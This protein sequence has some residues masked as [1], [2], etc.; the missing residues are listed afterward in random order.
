MGESRYGFRCRIR[1]AE[2][3]P[4]VLGQTCRGFPDDEDGLNNSQDY[5]EDRQTGE[6]FSSDGPLDCRV[7]STGNCRG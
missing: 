6:Q 5:L 2:N 1:L 4:C 7:K 3:Q